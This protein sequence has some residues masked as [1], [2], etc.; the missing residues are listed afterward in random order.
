MDLCAEMGPV[1]WI[2]REKYPDLG[3]FI[4][5]MGSKM[6]HQEE[7]DFCQPDKFEVAFCVGFFNSVFSGSFLYVLLFIAF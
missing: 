7:V 1:I 2:C 3:E 4:L 5:G 6:E